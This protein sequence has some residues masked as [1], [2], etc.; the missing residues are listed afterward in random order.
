MLSSAELS[1]CYLF[2]LDFKI[3]NVRLRSH[4]FSQIREKPSRLYN[5]GIS[6]LHKCY[7]RHVAVALEH[8][9]NAEGFWISVYTVI[10]SLL[11]DSES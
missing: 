11:Q 9:V 6:S 2:C 1:R 10:I 3:I 8:R 7:L 5:L 4:I